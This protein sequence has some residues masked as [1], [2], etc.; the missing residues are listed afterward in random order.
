MW[1]NFNYFNN[2]YWQRRPV[3]IHPLT[4]RPD[5]V[6]GSGS[7][8]LGTDSYRDPVETKPLPGWGY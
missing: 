2:P 4:N 6:S 5:L 8:I 7:L 1:G 3:Q